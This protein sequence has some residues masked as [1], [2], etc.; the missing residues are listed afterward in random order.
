MLPIAT[1]ANGKPSHFSTIFSVLAR[2]RSLSSAAADGM[3]LL[4]G[5]RRSVVALQSALPF[6]KM[7][8]ASVIFPLH[9]EIKKFDLLGI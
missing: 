9:I 8:W 2:S 3:D 6:I 5:A 1:R 4:S 7:G